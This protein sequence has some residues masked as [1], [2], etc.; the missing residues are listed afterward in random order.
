M[1]VEQ[2]G[3]KRG[4]FSGVLTTSWVT[5]RLVLWKGEYHKSMSSFHI[6]R[7]S[8]PFG[9]SFQVLGVVSSIKTL[10]AH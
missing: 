9:I 4:L 8:D 2:P 1:C 10:S 3:L 6:T 7:D 5:G